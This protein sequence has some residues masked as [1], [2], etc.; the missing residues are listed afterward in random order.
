MIGT[1]VTGEMLEQARQLGLPAG[2]TIVFTDGVRIPLADASVNMVWCCAV[3]RTAC[4]SPNRSVALSPAR[5]IGFSSRG[6]WLSTL[7]CT[8]IALPSV[9][10]PFED[11]GFATRDV[12]IIKDMTA[13]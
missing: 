9:C 3:L 10:R 13:E 7:K 2:C 12:R 5:C 4:W 1:E 8:S 11:A 6:A